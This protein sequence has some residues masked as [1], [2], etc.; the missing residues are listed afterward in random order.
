MLP[1]TSRSSDLNPKINT[2]KLL[3]NAQL[4]PLI[5]DTAMDPRPSAPV[6]QLEGIDLPSDDADG[7]DSPAPNS[8]AGGDDDSFSLEG[9]LRSSQIKHED[10][11][12]FFSAKDMSR[13][14]SK[15]KIKQELERL[16]ISKEISVDEIR[17]NEPEMEPSQPQK[18]QTYLR[19]FVLLLLVGRG[20]E[21]VQFIKEGV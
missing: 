10:G 13:I 16:Q 15:E 9:Q 18:G 5:Q 19:V 7:Q 6:L 2:G 20:V 11:T 3:G 17:S 14:L 1:T 4:C 8:T 21:I 12:Y